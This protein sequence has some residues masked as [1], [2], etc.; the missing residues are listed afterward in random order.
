MSWDGITE[1]RR[2]PRAEVRL[3]LA[4]DAAGE[5]TST[6]TELETLNLSAGGFYCNVNHPIEPLTHLGLR[7]VF[8]PFGPGQ[9]G[10]R[11][12]ACDAVVVRSDPAA[13]EPGY[14]RI[15]ACFTRIAPRDRELIASFVDWH[16]E[17]YA[18][19]HPARHQRASARQADRDDRAA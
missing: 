17:V 11:S 12:V 10:E 5:E 18:D 14:Y 7:F 19:D 6:A 16:N 8:P 3:R 13:D 2:H 1:R 15:A 9:D 4:F